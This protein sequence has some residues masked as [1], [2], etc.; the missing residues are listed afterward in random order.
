[1][2][3]DMNCNGG[4]RA[5]TVKVTH[6]LLVNIPRASTI[7]IA[8][9]GVV[10]FHRQRRP[11][12]SLC[13]ELCTTARTFSFT[14]CILVTVPSAHQIFSQLVKDSFQLLMR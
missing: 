4:T 2:H 9:I 5:P 3:V 11:V 10:S 7:V 14:L 6:S 1:M 13:L 8:M 12:H